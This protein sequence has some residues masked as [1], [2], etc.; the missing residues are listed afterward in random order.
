[1]SRLLDALGTAARIEAGRWEPATRPVDSLELAT[2]AEER[3]ETRGQGA[4]METDPDVVGRG[5]EALALAA[6]RHGP[7]ESVVWE[8]RGRDLTLSPV[9]PAAAPVV[10]GEETRDLGATVARLAIEALGGSLELDGETLRVR[11]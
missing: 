3:I 7:V 8:V 6:I 9:R 4:T 1:M 11:L 2:S 5:L 10:S